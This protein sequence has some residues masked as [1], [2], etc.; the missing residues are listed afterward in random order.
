MYKNL[1]GERMT[2][3]YTLAVLY[4]GT[5]ERPPLHN[6]EEREYYEKIKKEIDAEKDKKGIIWYVPNE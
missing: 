1:T 5:D 3:L 2:R 6:D 4:S